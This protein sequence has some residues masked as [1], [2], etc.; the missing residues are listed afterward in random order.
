MASAINTLRSTA[1][2]DD[3]ALAGLAR[4][5]RAAFGELYSRYFDRVYRYHLAHTGSQEDAQDLTAV[6][7]VAALESLGR[8]RP[9]GRFLPWLLTIARHKVAMFYRS[10]KRLQP[11]DSVLE[12]PDPGPEPEARV[13]QHWQEEGIARALGGL[14]PDRAEAIRLCIFSDLS[15]T[16][17]G[18]VMGKSAGAVKMLIHRGL[19]DLRSSS[20]SSMLEEQ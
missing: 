6:T 18:A 16:E 19:K 9:S 14:L 17:A 3:D 2:M 7:F 5:N 12:M 13:A 10:K 8:Y 15:A 20:L 11:L 1:M 4:E